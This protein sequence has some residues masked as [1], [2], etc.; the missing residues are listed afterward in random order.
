MVFLYVF[1][2]LA[3]VLLAFWCFVCFVM[4]FLFC[5]CLCFHVVFDMYVSF[6]H[7][8]CLLVFFIV[9]EP[10]RNR[11]IKY[12]NNYQIAVDASSTGQAVFEHFGKFLFLSLNLSN[13]QHKS[14]RNS[15]KHLP[16]HSSKYIPSKHPPKHPQITDSKQW[17]GT[18]LRVKQVLRADQSM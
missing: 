10:H 3:V 2:S 18:V 13:K 16:K 6:F 15:T 8:L 12:G 1:S 7:V 4:R 11:M 5:G 14:L 17:I 9:L